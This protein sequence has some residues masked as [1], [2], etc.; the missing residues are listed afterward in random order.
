MAV[1]TITSL[2]SVSVVSFCLPRTECALT[3]VLAIL[4]EKLLDLV[5]DFALGELDI[6]LGGTIIRHEGEEAVISH[7]KL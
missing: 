4:N 3:G 2:L 5:T 7:V 1:S 6:V